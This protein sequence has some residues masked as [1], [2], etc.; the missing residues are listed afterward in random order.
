MNATAAAWFVNNV[1]GARSHFD[2]W[3]CNLEIH[4]L[5]ARLLLFISEQ[6]N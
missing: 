2:Q 6:K 4:W 1:V 5:S 3:V